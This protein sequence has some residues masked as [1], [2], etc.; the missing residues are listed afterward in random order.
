MGPETS[1]EVDRYSNSGHME[2]IV[3]LDNGLIA[4]DSGGEGIHIWD[5]ANPDDTLAIYLHEN[6]SQTLQVWAIAQLP[7]GRIVSGDVEVN[8]HLWSVET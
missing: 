7:D 4:S 5:P 6:E 3:Q 1:L 8:I 2:A